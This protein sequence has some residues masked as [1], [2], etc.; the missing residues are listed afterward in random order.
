M[1]GLIIHTYFQP[2]ILVAQEK[3]DIKA[4]IDKEYKRKEQENCDYYKQ[5]EN[6]YYRYFEDW[7]MDMHREILI[8]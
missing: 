6:E 4:M 3:A 5:I 8:M 2:K 1:G 7:I